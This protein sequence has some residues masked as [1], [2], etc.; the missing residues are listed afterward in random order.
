MELGINV[1]LHGGILA[2]SKPKRKFPFQKHPGCSV[3]AL[4][5]LFKLFEAQDPMRLEKQ[6]A[7]KHFKLEH[8]GPKEG[9]QETQQK[10]LVAGHRC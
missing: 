2:D 7:F 9:L 5:F 1:C 4:F 8:E 6:K 3:V 10:M